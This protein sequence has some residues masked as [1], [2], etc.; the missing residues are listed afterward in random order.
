M[1][2]EAHSNLLLMFFFQFNLISNYLQHYNCF[3]FSLPNFTWTINDVYSVYFLWC[4][5]LVLLFWYLK[6]HLMLNLA[7]GN[8]YTDSKLH[9]PQHDRS[10]CHYN[11]RKYSFCSR[12]VNT[13][14]SLPNDIVEAET[15]NTFKNRLDKHWSNQ[16]VL[17]NFHADISGTGSLPICMWF[18]LIHDTCPSELIGLDWIGLDCVSQSVRS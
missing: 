18:Y 3:I 11:L 10:V 7:F 12:I 4:I 9:R 2:N 5:F 15:I 17:F 6:C 14:N 1:W 16:D 13:W 8:A